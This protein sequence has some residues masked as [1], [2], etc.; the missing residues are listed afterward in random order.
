[1]GLRCMI[2]STTAS[3]IAF[4]SV[5]VRF[6]WC[7]PA[8]RGDNLKLTA[9]ELFNPGPRQLCQDVTAVWDWGR[10]RS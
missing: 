5:S 10:R 2:S 6:S 1:M 7:A 4:C 8:R 3:L 9:F